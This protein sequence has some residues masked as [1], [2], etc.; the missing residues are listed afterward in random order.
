VLGGV[1]QYVE[2]R[3]RPRPCFVPGTCVATL[4]AGIAHAPVLVSEM[5]VL[6]ALPNSMAH[7]SPSVSG[8]VVVRAERTVTRPGTGQC[9][10]INVVNVLVGLESL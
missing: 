10:A 3:H 5:C 9:R 6:L 2:A 7:G 1:L 4:W 8:G